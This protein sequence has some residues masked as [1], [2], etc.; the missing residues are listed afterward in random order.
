VD[1]NL[2]LKNYIQTD[3]L[4]KL[5][6]EVILQSDQV[7]A[8]NLC[9]YHTKNAKLQFFL[10]NLEKTQLSCQDALTVLNENKL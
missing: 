1:C 9:L 8:I 7:E 4:L 3:N 5:I 6:E 10:G 2:N